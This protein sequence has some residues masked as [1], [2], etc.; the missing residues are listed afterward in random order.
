[1]SDVYVLSR[2]LIIP[3]ALRKMLR[4]KLIVSIVYFVF[5]LSEVKTKKGIGNDVE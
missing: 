5:I 2:L 3:A 1:M 4:D